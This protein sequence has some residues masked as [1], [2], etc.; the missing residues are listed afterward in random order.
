MPVI[1]GKKY[2]DVHY[3]GIIQA[4]PPHGRRYKYPALAILG[5]GHNFGH[6]VAGSVPPFPASPTRSG[7]CLNDEAKAQKLGTPQTVYKDRRINRYQNKC[8]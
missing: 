5:F 1:V 6:V 8:A 7:G 4:P 3:P 2:S